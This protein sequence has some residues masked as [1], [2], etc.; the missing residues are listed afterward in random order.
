MR[1]CFISNLFPPYGRGGAERVVEEEALALKALGHDVSIITACPVREDGSAEPRM[2]V[3]NG[4]RVYRFFPLNLFFYGELGQHPA[5]V[6]LLWHLRD[7]GNDHAARTVERILKIERPEIVHTHN[8][9]GIGFRVPAVIRKLG[10][11]HAHTLHDVQLVAPSGLILKGKEHAFGVADPLSRLFAAMARSRFGSPD[12]VIS[13]SRFLL[14]F[15]AERGFFPQSQK[16]L[17]PNPA[18]HVVPSKHVL[19]GETRFL[20]LGQ[21]ETHK[22]ILLLIEA[23]RRLVKERP[24]ARLDVVGAGSGLEEARRTAGKDVRISFYGKKKPAQFADMFSKVDYTVVPSLCYENAPTVIVESFAYGV[25][26]AAASIGGATE[27]VR[28]EKN[29]FAFEAGNVGALVA[30]MTRACDE[31]GAWPERSRAAVRTAE[32]L[33]APRHADR[34]EALYEGRDPAFEEREPIVPMRY[35]PS[36]T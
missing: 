24:K 31:K 30:T 20:F 22:G 33:V 2:T 29:G 17:L 19:S 15:H 32:L 26:V 35:E 8:L 34:L 3:E 27:L 12:V 23:F 1:I 4:L 25:P 21:V 6:R 9:K 5:P 10:I 11:R 18:P 28:H 7:A 14:R 13:P 16:I 36:L